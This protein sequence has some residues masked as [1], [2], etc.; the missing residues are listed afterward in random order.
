MRFFYS[1]FIGLIL[2]SCYSEERTITF[3]NQSEIKI[4]S[5]TVG[6]SSADSYSITHSDIEKSDTVITSIP[7]NIPK[8]NNHDITI[9][10][11]IYIKNHDLIYKYNYDDLAGH[12]SNDYTIVLTKEKKVKWIM[13]F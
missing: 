2:C 6:V 8:S 1:L 9:F 11:S 3:I 4:D 7:V 10:I 5:I 12:L 13:Q